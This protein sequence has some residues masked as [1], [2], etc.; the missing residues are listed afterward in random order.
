MQIRPVGA[1]SFHAES[2]IDGQENGQNDEA[3]SR[4]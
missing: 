4:F 1:L 2:R 3:N